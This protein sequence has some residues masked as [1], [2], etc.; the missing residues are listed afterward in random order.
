MM[1]QGLLFFEFILLGFTEL[2]DYI[3]SFTK[4]RKN[5]TIVSENI[6]LHSFFLP[7]VTPMS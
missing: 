7:F 1:Y 4:F 2:L 3:V 5:L 6:F